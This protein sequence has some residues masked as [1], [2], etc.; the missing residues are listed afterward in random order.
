MRKVNTRHGEWELHRRDIWGG[1]VS[2]QG[3]V[4][5]AAS[6]AGRK[7]NGPFKESLITYYDRQAGYHPKEVDKDGEPLALLRC[8]VL[9]K[10]LITPKVCA[11]HL[12][13]HSRADDLPLLGLASTET[14]NPRNGLL[15]AKSIEVAFDKKE[16]CFLY[17]PFDQK[18]YFCVLNPSLLP[19]RIYNPDPKIQDDYDYPDT[20][21]S[22]NNKPLQLP[23]GV[24][25][26]KR[27]LGFHARCTFKSARSKW[28]TEE[29]YQEFLVQERVAWKFSVDAPWYSEGAVDPLD[30]FEK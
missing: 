25:P 6:G 27:I 26:Y 9:D 15:L 16:A 17:N 12:W 28:I 20:F 10:P 4:A 8:M 21:A 30:T 19:I 2:S 18:F 13:S 22:L 11:S 3:S 29:R 14:E 23:K 24:F 1:S 5:S 7:N